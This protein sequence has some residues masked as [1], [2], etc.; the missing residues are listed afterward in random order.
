MTSKDTVIWGADK[1]S[2]DIHKI[3]A[4]EYSGNFVS[5][6]LSTY[7]VLAMAAYGADG[8]SAQQIRQTLFLPKE[9]KDDMQ[10][11]LG[12]Q[13]LIDLLNIA[14]RVDLNFANKIYVAKHLDIKNYFKKI[15]GTYFRS[16]SETI[17]FKMNVESAKAI[18]DWCIEKTNGNIKEIVK[19][20]DLDED[21]RML[22]LNAAYF[23]GEWS[24]KFNPEMTQKRSFHIDRRTVIQNEDFYMVIILPDEIEG[25]AEI[26]KNLEKVYFNPSIV[27]HEL[28]NISLPK[29][30]IKSTLD[31][32]GY[33]KK[34]GMSDVFTKKANF[35]GMCDEDAHISQVLQK[36]FIE[37]EEE[38]TVAAATTGEIHL[39]FLLTEEMASKEKTIDVNVIKGAEKFITNFHKQ[40]VAYFA[41]LNLYHHHLQLSH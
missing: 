21:M 24:H 23:K 2:T 11:Q 34:L 41:V 25:F 10:F 14:Q 8:T 33:L 20:D 26:G 5:S 1:L 6:G 37:V 13:S 40:Q 15:T 30:K 27:D 32:N 12:F 4:N 17:D 36:S 22:L 39:T 3:I 16:I 9:Y 38:G 7:M 29:F 35:K 19:P 18:N 31:L 28:L